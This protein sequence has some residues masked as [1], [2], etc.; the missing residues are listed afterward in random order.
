MTLLAHNSKKN[1]Q[2]LF[3]LYFNLFILFILHSHTNVET[4]KKKLFTQY[5]R[6]I[7]GFFSTYS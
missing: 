3:F 6:Q 1:F 4:N 7:L 2:I 5:F